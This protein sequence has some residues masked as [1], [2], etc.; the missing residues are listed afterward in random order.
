MALGFMLKLANVPT[1][2]LDYPKINLTSRG[3]RKGIWRDKA[4]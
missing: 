4:N 2:F 3:L 1:N